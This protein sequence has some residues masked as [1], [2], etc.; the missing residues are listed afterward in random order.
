MCRMAQGFFC[1]AQLRAS[2]AQG[3]QSDGFCGKHAHPVPSPRTPG[4]ASGLSVCVSGRDGPGCA[5]R[6]AF[7]TQGL[8]SQ[9]GPSQAAK[10]RVT[11][12][13]PT[14]TL[15]TPE[16]TSKRF[17]SKVTFNKSK[18]GEA[19]ATGHRASSVLV[20]EPGAGR[21][22]GGC[23]PHE[24]PVSW[25]HQLV[26]L[27]EAGV[28]SS[29]M[30]HAGWSLNTAHGPAGAGAGRSSSCSGHTAARTQTRRQVRPREA[31]SPR[32]AGVGPHA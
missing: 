26:V 16:A 10:A 13:S 24:A 31:G 4:G 7:S 8:R 14:A 1:P 12:Q 21:H 22:V 11:R 32:C 6:Q 28:K 9:D 20:S 3:V 30:T 27:R 5:P 17:V 18:C 29:E 23:G 19:P 15:L 2:L 25:L